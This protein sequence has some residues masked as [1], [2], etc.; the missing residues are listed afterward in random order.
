MC[1]NIFVVLF[2]LN[3]VLHKLHK[4]QLYFD[5]NIIYNVASVAFIIAYKM[6]LSG[7]FYCFRIANYIIALL[8]CPPSVSSQSDIGN[9]N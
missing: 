4:F 7:V 1:L 8:A 3:F 2:Y 9:G 6:V 5:P